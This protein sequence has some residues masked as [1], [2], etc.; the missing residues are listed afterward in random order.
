MERLTKDMIGKHVL[1][2]SDHS[3][4]HL[5]VLVDVEGTSVRLSDSRRLWEW[6]V[7]SGAGISLSE[8][9]IVGIDQ[10][11]SRIT[12]TLPDLIV[13]GVCEVIPAYGMSVATIM[14]ADTSKPA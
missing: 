3:G 13:T 14:G 1:I 8:V 12:E 2:R 5:G 4:V 6:R 9:A 11:R 10:T 7:A